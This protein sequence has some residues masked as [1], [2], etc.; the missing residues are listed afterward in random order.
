MRLGLVSRRWW[1]RLAVFGVLLPGLWPSVGAAVPILTSGSVELETGGSFFGGGI[2]VTTSDNATIIAGFSTLLFAFGP[3]G[4]IVSSLGF[5]L[6]YQAPTVVYAGQTFLQCG[7]NPGSSGIFPCAFLSSISLSMLT[8]TPPPP[9]PGGPF[10]TTVPGTFSLS[11]LEVDLYGSGA[12][13]VGS[14]GGYATVSGPASLTFQWEPNIDQWS[15]S[16]G[17][18]Q[19]VT[20]EPTT[21]LLFGTSAA[22]LGLAWRKRR[23]TEHS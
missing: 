11:Q 10:S 20:P 17:E 4:A 1:R 7:D 14:L 8:Q 6:F 22:G 13:L 23:R 19:F 5:G 18:A 16:D 12:H 9:L 15:F 3:T 2:N 21:L